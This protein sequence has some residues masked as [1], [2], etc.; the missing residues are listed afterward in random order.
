MSG[1]VKFTLSK[2][3]MPDSFN[4]TDRM[5]FSDWESETSNFLSARD[6]E[7]AE[8]ILEWIAQEPEDVAE[9][10]FDRIA[11]QRGWAGQ[12]RDHATFAKYLF[13][14]LQPYRWDVASI[15]EKRETQSRS[16]R[17]ETATHGGRTSDQRDGTRIHEEVSGHASS[18]NSLRCEQ[19]NA[20]VRR[21]GAEGTKST[22]TR[23]Y[24]NDLKLQR[25]HDIHPTPL[26]QTVGAGRQRRVSDIRVR[27]AKSKHLD[28][29][30]FDGTSET[31]TWG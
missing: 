31:W 5:K 2:V 9:D 14:V 7:H 11:V 13:T 3:M 8:D 15:S 10:K 22:E 30:E 16:E 21:T 4:G 20:D 29:D 25:L 17:M 19:R 6:H 1:Y 18:K 27:E 24:D 12:A 23:R 28:T 26:E